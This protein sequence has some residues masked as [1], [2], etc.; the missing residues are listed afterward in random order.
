MQLSVCHPALLAAIAIA[1]ASAAA[2]LCDYTGPVGNA[3][4]FKP[5]RNFCCFLLSV[6]FLLLQLLLLK[7]VLLPF[8]VTASAAW[9][10]SCTRSSKLQKNSSLLIT[11]YSRSCK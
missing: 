5:L 7:R 1:A 3:L 9:N 11:S 6:S 4:A 10:C 2:L 8:C